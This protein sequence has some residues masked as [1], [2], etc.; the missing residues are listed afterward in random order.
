MLLR[1]WLL[2]SRVGD[3]QERPS[4]TYPLVATSH[5]GFQRHPWPDQWV[6]A[7]LSSVWPQSDWIWRLPTHSSPV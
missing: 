6:Y 5:L 4:P 2:R 1:S 3:S 7:T